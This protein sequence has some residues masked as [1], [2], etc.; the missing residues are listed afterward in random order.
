MV[1]HI[2]R[3]YEKAQKLNVWSTIKFKSHFKVQILYIKH[4]V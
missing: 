2:V 3:D 1:L 4:Y